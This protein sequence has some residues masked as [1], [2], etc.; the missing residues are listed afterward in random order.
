MAG[1]LDTSSGDR[2]AA[3]NSGGWMS[4]MGRQRQFVTIGC[5]RSAPNLARS[6]VGMGERPLSLL[7]TFSAAWVEVKFQGR[8]VVRWENRRRLLLVV[9]A[10]AKQQRAVSDPALSQGCSAT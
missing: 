6:S 8:P 7:P 1:W 2:F 5:S 9:S 4:L 10:P 3:A